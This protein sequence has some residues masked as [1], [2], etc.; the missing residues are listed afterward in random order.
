MNI[1]RGD[2]KP[3][4]ISVPLG[5]SAAAPGIT[6]RPPPRVALPA[7]PAPPPPAPP[8]SPEVDAADLSRAMH[9]FANPSKVK[10]G[11]SPSPSRSGSD[12][13]EEDEEDESVRTG[14]FDDDD[15]ESP[16]PVFAP[17]PV[18]KPSAGYLTI[19]DEKADIVFKL[20][21]LK[22]NGVSSG[23][24]WTM[25]SDIREMRAELARI[26]TELEL[27]RSLKFSR[28]ALVGIA[29][30]IEFFNDKVDI[31][32]LELDGWSEQMHQMVYTE[33]EYDD[34]LE[35]LFF[36]YRGS[37][38]TPPEVRLMLA[39]GGSA[40]SFHVANSMFK[41][42]P[43]AADV[44]KHQ[45]AAK[46]IQTRPEMRGPKH[47]LPPPNHQINPDTRAGR[48]ADLPF[49]APPPFADRP[50]EFPGFP[51]PVHT[52]DPVPTRMVDGFAGFGR[53]IGM[54]GTVPNAGDDDGSDRLSDVP[55]DLESVPSDMSSPDE[56]SPAPK[57]RR[58][59]AKPKPAA[60]ERRVF[61]I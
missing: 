24:S 49:D 32:D 56:D 15:Y 45:Q 20:Q 10:P 55:S 31:L 54:D 5:N 9:D 43:A 23:R 6:L 52:D 12:F 1:Q 35:E 47:S 28:K 44:S 48:G 36:K 58:T 4:A 53:P 51:N 37:M 59:A 11:V 57:R 50:I 25:S 8:M 26:K 34:V 38:K 2:P 40:F 17:K 22:K 42:P 21:R 60:R 3:Q 7:R 61:E 41:K 27:D 16:D 46:T 14:D 29:S 30:A 33:K 13:D 19:D 18:D 39:V